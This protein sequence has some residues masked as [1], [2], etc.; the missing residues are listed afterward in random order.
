MMLLLVMWVVLTIWSIIYINEFY[1]HDVVY[2]GI[3]EPT[4]NE[5]GEVEKG[6]LVWGKKLFVL[7]NFC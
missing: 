5:D 3:G 4:T 1:E 7:F 2:M 6:L